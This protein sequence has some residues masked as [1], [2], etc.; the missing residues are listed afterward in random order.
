VAQIRVSTDKI[1]KRGQKIEMLEFDDGEA[2]ARAE[3]LRL[4]GRNL[5][6]VD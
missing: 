5:R 6:A 4:H 1:V 3:M 2:G